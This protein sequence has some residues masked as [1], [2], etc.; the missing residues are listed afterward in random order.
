MA[1]GIGR[2]GGAAPRS[3]GSV[4]SLVGPE[5]IEGG[6]GGARVATRDV[7]DGCDCVGLY[8][9]A[10]WCP[11]C[12]GFTPHL[13]RAYKALRSNGRRMRVIFVSSD[14]SSGEFEGYLKE[15]P[16]HAVPFTASQR[17]TLG[18]VFSVRGIPTLVL[19]RP[20]GTLLTSDGRA[21]LSADP[22]GK[23]YPWENFQ[24]PP[25]PAMPNNVKLI[26]GFLVAYML[27]R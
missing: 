6:G 16:W 3:Y 12:R 17:R 23:D 8:F 11:P 15:Q 4:E 20:D 26:I 7:L 19:L 13:A 25:V 14:N 24:G 5:L 21:A 18:S 10:H 9:S 22:A 2:A 1:A 27:W